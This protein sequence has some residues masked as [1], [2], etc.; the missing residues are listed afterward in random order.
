MFHF[1]YDP[2]RAAG[3]RGKM[4]IDFSF[5]VL[6]KI[7]LK[8]IISLVLIGLVITHKITRVYFIVLSRA[9]FDNLLLY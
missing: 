5:A 7:S 8:I 9:L 2:E 6:A 3:L 1:N 4:Q